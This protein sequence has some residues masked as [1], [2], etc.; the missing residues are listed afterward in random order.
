MPFTDEDQKR[1]D[2]LNSVLGPRT[3]PPASPDLGALTRIGEGF[4][5][6]PSNVAQTFVNVGN[7]VANFGQAPTEQSTAWQVPKPYDIPAPQGFGERAA[8]MLP[9]LAATVAA[10]LIPG[11]AATRVASLLGAGRAAPIIGDIAGGAFLGASQSPQEAAAQGTEFGAIG[12]LN[13]A[14]I[15]WYLKAVGNAA[16][17]VGGQLLRGQNPLDQQ[18]LLNTATNVAVPL[19][20]GHGSPESARPL[21]PPTP[22]EYQGLGE[23]RSPILPGVA[24]PPTQ[25]VFSDSS[26]LDSPPVSTPLETVTPP[27]YAQ[28]VDAPVSGEAP[29]VRF[30]DDGIDPGIQSNSQD[31]LAPRIGGE[32]ESPVEDSEAHHEAIQ[33]AV[34]G[35]AQQYPGVAVG[36][37]RSYDE[38]PEDV[39]ARVPEEYRTAEG[40]N[41]PTTGKQF[42]VSGQLGDT[43]RARDVAVHEIVGHY[44][45]DKIIDPSEW[46]GIQDHVFTNG[47]DI[48]E[49][50]S[51]NYH[52]KGLDD[53]DEGQQRRVTREYIARLSEDTTLDPTLWQRV[54][55]AVRSALRKIGINR[56]WS[57]EEIK[58]L[59]RSAH[60]NLKR[61]ASG[62]DLISGAAEAARRQAAPP[63]EAPVREAY[64]R[65]TEKTGFPSVAISDL[66]RESGRP[67]DEVKSLLSAKHQQ[68][69]AILSQGDWSTASEDKRSGAI[70]ANNGYNGPA[71]NL[72]VRL[73]PEADPSLKGRA[74]KSAED[75]TQGKHSLFGKLSRIA[76][77]DFGFG[78]SEDITSA[79]EKGRGEAT[80]LFSRAQ[81]VVKQ[82]IKSTPSERKAIGLFEASEKTPGDDA[83]FRSSV[84]PETISAYREGESIISKAQ[85]VLKS[86]TNDPRKQALLSETRGEYRSTNYAAFN[87]PVRWAKDLDSDPVKAAA[88]AGQME[89]DQTLGPDANRMDIEQA[90]GAYKEEILR[91]GDPFTESSGTNS[92]ISRT[93]WI[94][95]QDLTPSQWKFMEDF[96]RNPK[97]DAHEKGALKDILDKQSLNHADQALVAR[98]GRNAAKLF[99]DEEA[100]QL[101]DISQRKTLSK[102]LRAFLGEYKDPAQRM[103]FTMQKLINNA[104]QAKTISE[105]SE[106]GKAGK[107]DIFNTLERQS[108]IKSATPDRISE[109]RALR[110]I[111]E[112]PAFGKLAGKYV[113]R[114]VADALNAF[115]ENW[116]GGWLKSFSGL[117]S[118]IK[119]SLV[120]WNPASHARQW[121]QTP[122]LAMAARVSPLDFYKYGRQIKA[123]EAELLENHIIGAD[124]SSQD[125]Q[126]GSKEM[127]LMFNPT[128][129][130]KAISAA[131]NA[132]AFVQKIYGMPDNILRSIAYLKNKEVLLKEG[133][134]IQESKDGALKFTNRYTMNYGQVSNA[135]SIG[136]ETP[137]VSPFLSYQEQMLKVLKNL[138]ED[139]I[140]GSPGDR[141]YAIGNLGALLAA[142]LLLAQTG[143]S[144]LSNDDRKEWDRTLRLSPDYATGQIRVPIRRKSDGSFDYMNIGN[145]VPAGDTGALARNILTGDLNGVFKSNPFVGF[146]KSPVL[147]T[148]SDQVSG[149]DSV[150][151]QEFQGPGDRA[152]ALAKQFLPPLTP[153]VGYEAGRVAN[154]LTP[155]NQGGLGIINARTGRSDTPAT[156]LLG[157]IGLRAS[158]VQPAALI[159][160]AQSDAKEQQ[161]NA[162]SQLAQV[163]GTN[164]SDSAMQAALMRYSE[165][166]QQIQRDLI[167]KIGQ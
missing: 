122:L 119:N 95:K 43:A 35:V 116:S 90:I 156:A 71:K 113:S 16:I 105:L 38:L 37:V 25:R 129:T 102:E 13:K 97:L 44:G 18:S 77:K 123:N 103:A 163:T 14:P 81:P 106:L 58:G 52:G 46:R 32:S 82:L 39:K 83:L 112:N 36:V 149:R 61:G 124:Y 136:R 26:P 74:G 161:E 127:D 50:I 9:G 157:Q 132:Q 88:L 86:A 121:I 7:N 93:L 23:E 120:T 76:E 54:T 144:S 84:R 158:T 130:D 2:Y 162:R 126:R 67:L 68:G 73:L 143:R 166:A 31:N 128:R 141:A 118:V 108:A 147:N 80:T 10:S 164:A 135:A 142:P 8:D 11:G 27:F 104:R 20:L 51:Q 53:L 45:V 34:N 17:P 151:D 15:P 3:A 137:F 63:A 78:K 70:E 146:D 56:D 110:Q 165:K 96:Q 1:L 21:I 107:L 155:N 65:L 75:Q 101:T 33:S 4:A 69:K 89:R 55:A 91:G 5:D 98:L 131:R 140:H 28:P 49:D 19:I 133:K 42:L 60:Q 92:K 100:K 99:T 145:I 6:L 117:T 138:S 29:Y 115:N 64:N 167:R 148:I 62:D 22:V 160:R 150:T 41:D 59:I 153:G 57:D 139:A 12:L 48:A 154:A 152:K 40:F 79:Q 72:L 87:D 109:L 134:S 94:Q 66:A 125:I 30:G 111:P 159:R 114:D 85:D 24:R 47:R